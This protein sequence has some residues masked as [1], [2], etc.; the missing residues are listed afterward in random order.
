[1]PR[2]ADY[3]S[4]AWVVARVACPLAGSAWLDPHR[5]WRPLRSPCALT[6]A[7]EKSSL[8][9]ATASGQRDCRRRARDSRQRER[10]C[11]ASIPI[12]TSAGE[13]N[14]SQRPD[15]AWRDAKS[16]RFSTKK[17]RFG[18]GKCQA[19]MNQSWLSRENYRARR[20]KSRARA[21]QVPSRRQAMSV[22]QREVLLSTGKLRCG[23]GEHTGGDE[24]LASE[25]RD[26]AGAAMEVSVRCCR[27]PGRWVGTTCYVGAGRWPRR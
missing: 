13:G 19:E 7:S 9:R 11:A 16:A 8:A 21:R 10:R 17:S 14:A 23:Q 5:A 26:G 18:T 1:L 12:S 25:E 27:G 6:R 3:G 20:A 15:N 24:Q 2:R 4:S 22:G